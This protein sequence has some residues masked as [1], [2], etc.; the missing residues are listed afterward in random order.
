MK[1]DLAQFPP[2]LNGC[3]HLEATE[4]AQ[5][6]KLVGPAIKQIYSAQPDRPP[7]DKLS[8]L[9]VLV[10]QWVRGHAEQQQAKGGA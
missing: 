5:L 1:L 2:N 3:R 9:L 10:A 7:E 4:L 8:L 6:G